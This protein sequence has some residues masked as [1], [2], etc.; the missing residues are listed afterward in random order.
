M[1]MVDDQQAAL[2][3]LVA[4]RR[5]VT[6]LVFEVSH[7]LLARVAGRRLDLDQLSPSADLRQQVRRRGRARGGV[8]I[9]DRDAR[10]RQDSCDGMWPR[11]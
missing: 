4:V 5:P 10:V 2:D 3:R 6:Q 7:E 11:S 8:K 1:L 9:D